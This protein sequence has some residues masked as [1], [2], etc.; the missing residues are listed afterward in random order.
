MTSLEEIRRQGFVEHG[1]SSLRL[2]E[3]GPLADLSFAAKDLMDVS[4]FKSGWG[5]PDRLRDADPAV[6]TAPA[7]LAPL[8]A[9]ARLVG[10]THTDE[11]A[12][13]MF[14]MNPHFG[15]PIN[16]NAPA[17]PSEPAK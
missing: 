9:G 8:M 2:K 5:N 10:K 7:V 13:G 11:V 15:T 1:P 3:D 14:G 12:C 17:A 6:A 16:P 4:G